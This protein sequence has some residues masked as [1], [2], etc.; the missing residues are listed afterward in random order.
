MKIKKNKPLGGL[1]AFELY[2]V[3]AAFIISPALSSSPMGGFVGAG[4]NFSSFFSGYAQIGTEFFVKKT[5][6]WQI[7][8]GPMLGF[9]F[10]KE[11]YSLDVNGFIK[12]SYIFRLAKEVGLGAYAKIPAG[13]TISVIED[14]SNLGFNIGAAPGISLEFGE[15]WGLFAELGYLHHINFPLDSGALFQSGNFPAGLILAGLNYQFN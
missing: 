12:A 14:I 4:P 6:G 9:G 13:L 3:V 1:L 15:K 7:S 10:A 11:Y 8:Y 2:F 5:Y